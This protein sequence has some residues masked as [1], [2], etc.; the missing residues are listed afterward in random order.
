[1][2]QFQIDLIDDQ[3]T[4]KCIWFESRTSIQPPAGRSWNVEKSE[5]DINLRIFQCFLNNDNQS[6]SASISFPS[7]ARFNA[8]VNF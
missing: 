4:S 7:E 8:E 2:E 6:T 3:C 1:M 5:N